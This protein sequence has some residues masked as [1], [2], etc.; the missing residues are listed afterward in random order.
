MRAVE[1]PQSGFAIF[2]DD[3]ALRPVADAA[4]PADG[5]QDTD[6]E[7]AIGIAQRAGLVSYRVEIAPDGTIAIVVGTPT[8]PP[9]DS[10]RSES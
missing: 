10:D 6:V 2:P 9:A 4:A 5:W 8:D 7:R 3:D 1:G